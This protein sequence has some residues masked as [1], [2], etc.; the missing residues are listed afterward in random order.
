MLAGPL[1]T[2]M[3]VLAALHAA[4][5]EGKRWTAFFIATDIAGAPA[6]LGADLFDDDH[7]K[8]RRLVYEQ[9]QPNGASQRL[10]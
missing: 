4:G 9:A 3:G 7:A 10:M 8:A 1:Y 2:A 5:R 6:F